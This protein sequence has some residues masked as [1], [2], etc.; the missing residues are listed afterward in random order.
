ASLRESVVHDV[1]E[2]LDVLR[3]R[4]DLVLAAAVLRVRRPDEGEFPPGEHEGHPS[5]TGRQRDRPTVSDPGSGDQDVDPFRRPETEPRAHAL[6]F[7][8]PYTRRVHDRFRADRGEA[9]ALFVED[10]SPDD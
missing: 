6:E 9:P 1:Q 3:S 5:I 8:H 10:S 4:L 7:V 2:I